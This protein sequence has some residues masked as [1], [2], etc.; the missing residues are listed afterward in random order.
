MKKE[1]QGKMIRKVCTTSATKLQ[2]NWT[3]L[4][5]WYIGVIVSFTPILVE[6]F[7]YLKDHMYLDMDFWFKICTKGDVLWIL[8]TLLVLTLV[9]Y[10]VGDTKRSSCDNWMS[11]LGLLIWGV[12]CMI[13]IIFKYV[14]PEGFSGTV[15][16]WSCG[17]IGILT[18]LVCTGLQSG[19]TEVTKCSQ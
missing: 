4:I 17:I 11:V 12:C 10:Y 5:I 1:Y 13:W 9:E 8:A 7:I 19:N 15:V 16:L 2:V 18:L 3:K 14:Y 6:V